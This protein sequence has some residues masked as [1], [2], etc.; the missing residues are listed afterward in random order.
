MLLDWTGLVHVVCNEK[1]A[2]VCMQIF[3][4]LFEP[5]QLDDLVLGSV[6]ASR[7]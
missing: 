4:F 6:I 5:K 2:S 3:G 7:P 1:L